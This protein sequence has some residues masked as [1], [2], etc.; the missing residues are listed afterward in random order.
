VEPV[1]VQQLL[2]VGCLGD[3]SRPFTALCTL[4]VFP[5]GLDALLEE[6][7]VGSVA[8]A[9][10]WHDIVVQTAKSGQRDGQ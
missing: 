9:T 8:Q 3:V 6:V 10:G 2:R 7:K 1:S 5:L 4:G